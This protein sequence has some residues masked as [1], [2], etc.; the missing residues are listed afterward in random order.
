MVDDVFKAVGR[1]AGNAPRPDGRSDP[2]RVPVNI[3]TNEPAKSDVRLDDE[4]D[5]GTG[6]DEGGDGI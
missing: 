5:L 3:D 4:D 2:D 6:E 1:E